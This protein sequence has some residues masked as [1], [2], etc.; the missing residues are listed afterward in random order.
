MLNIKKV[1]KKNICFIGLMG[2]GKSVIAREL[3]RI[4]NMNYFD[5]DYEIE[6]ENGQTINEIFKKK[7]EGYFRKLEEKKCLELLEKQECI[8]SLGGG[9][10]TNEKI[11]KR[12]KKNS[13]S[14]FLNVDIDILVNRLNNSKKRPLLKNVNK[15]EKLEEILISRKKYYNEANLIIEN[16]FKKDLVIDIIKK[17]INH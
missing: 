7:G 17:K 1:G 3:S 8:I 16:N 12:I 9:S 2:S 14:I 6:K 10:I 15:K 13:Y 4:S 5:S 11:R